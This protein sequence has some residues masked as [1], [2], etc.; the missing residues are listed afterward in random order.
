MTLIPATLLTAPLLGAAFVFAPLSAAE[1]LSS[2]DADAAA[3]AATDVVVVSEGDAIDGRVTVL[4][5]WLGDA[6][7]GTE[8]TFEALTH[9]REE[10]ART[11]ETHF[12]QDL[13]P[14]EEA[15]KHVTGDRMVLFLLRGEGGRLGFTD[16]RIGDVPESLVWL[17]EG[18]AFARIQRVNPGSNG[19]GSVGTTTLELRSQVERTLALRDGIRLIATFNDPLVCVMAIAPHCRDAR[20][21]VQD[22]AFEILAA[23]GP[24]GAA[25]LRVLALSPR[26]PNLLFAPRVLQAL[27]KASPKALVSTVNE[28]LGSEL[29]YWASSS[30]PESWWSSS[31]PVVGSRDYRRAR[32]GRLM[33]SLRS[34]DDLDQ[35]SDVS[36]LGSSRDAVVALKTLWET[37]PELASFS[38]SQVGNLCSR[39]LAA[40]GGF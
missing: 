17:E 5:A 30:L 20:R 33:A 2:F 24:S 31:E 6:V 37:R 38:K 22:D 25:Y 39:I 3:W 40:Q 36:N 21:F 27:G 12:L 32:Y 7:P 11:V 28:M 18:R 4:E 14:E 13:M 19:I 26:E 10:T 8:L 15:V 35:E 23:S 16:T 34:L 9:Y 29:E 1:Q